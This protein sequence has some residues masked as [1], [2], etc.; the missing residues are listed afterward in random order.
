MACNPPSLWCVFCPF[1]GK[2]GG[3]PLSE[4][5]TAPRRAGC[6]LKGRVWCV[7]Y[8]L[9]G[10][11]GPSQLSAQRTAPH[12]LRRDLPAFLWCVLF[13]LEGEPGRGKLSEQRTAWRAGG[14]GLRGHGWCVCYPLPDLA[15]WRKGPQRTGITVKNTRQ[16]LW[17]L[18]YPQR[19]YLAVFMVCSRD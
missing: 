10:E 11:R 17:T 5:R 2:P 9:P 3:L 16:L 19:C 12:P 7:C 18:S 14:C 4:Q 1:E 15:S 13:P 6:G 8:P